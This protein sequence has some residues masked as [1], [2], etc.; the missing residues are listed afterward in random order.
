[1]SAHRK[2]I[3][4]LVGRIREQRNAIKALEEHVEGIE[5]RANHYEEIASRHSASLAE[6]RRDAD[7]AREDESYRDYQRDEVLR[8]IGRARECGD[9]WAEQRLLRELESL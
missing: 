8:K 4:S 6:A 2:L 3:L 5:I 7:R 1:M 9:N